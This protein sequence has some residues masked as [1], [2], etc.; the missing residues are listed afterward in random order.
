MF[1]EF[2]I[3]AVIIG[4]TLSLILGFFSFITWEV[5]GILIAISLGVPALIAQQTSDTTQL[6]NKKHGKY[7]RNETIS[8]SPSDEY[9]Y[10]LE[11]DKGKPLKGKI[12]STF[13]VNVYFLDEKNFRKWDKEKN[14]DYE[15]C[16]ESV[17]HAEINFEVPKSGTWFVTIE[18]NG[19][20]TAKTRVVLY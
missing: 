9:Y 2:L 18:N 12:K 10:E 16:H 8:V 19:R 4:I 1:R 13:P 14:Y 11:L 3:L 15:A 7:L 5:A 6:G 17:L 20:S